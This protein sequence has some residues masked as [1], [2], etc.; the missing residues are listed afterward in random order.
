M[1]TVTDTGPRGCAKYLT[2]TIACNPPTHTNE[3]RRSMLV[4]APFYRRKLKGEMR[5]PSYIGWMVSD[6]ILSR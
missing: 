5:S 4:L 6:T 2:H 3:P 1:L